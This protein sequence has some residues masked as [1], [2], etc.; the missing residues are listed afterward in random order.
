MALSRRTGL[1]LSGTLCGALALGTAGWTATAYTTQAPADAAA[2]AQ[3]APAPDALRRAAGQGVRAIE[4]NAI[5]KEAADVAAGCAAAHQAQGPKAG[6]CA[7]VREQL[8][9]LGR[10][11]AGLE[12]QA[13][14]GRPDL[15]AITA[16]TLDAV[17]ATVQLAKERARSDDGWGHGR[18]GREGPGGLIGTVQGL[19]TGLAGTMNGV[20]GGI[21]NM[22]IGLVRALLAGG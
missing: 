14:S 8:D 7:A 18:Q 19:V 12:R 10:A 5:G 15:G 2:P 3:A 9:R 22:V 11:R 16:S 6:S 21:S 17:G 20:V 1:L 4:E 13:N